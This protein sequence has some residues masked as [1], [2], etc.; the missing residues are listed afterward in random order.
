M[1]YAKKFVPIVIN[2]PLPLNNYFDIV[3]YNVK[4]EFKFDAVKFS[5]RLIDGAASSR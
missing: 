2:D 1:Q 3:Q 5:E 4:T